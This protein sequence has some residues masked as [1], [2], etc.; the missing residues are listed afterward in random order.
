LSNS[1]SVVISAAKLLEHIVILNDFKARRT[2]TSRKFS[3][4]LRRSGP[5]QVARAR[6]AFNYMFQDWF[7]HY[8]TSEP[9]MVNALPPADSNA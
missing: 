3:P 5:P 7:A 9:A 1:I 8:E 2:I 4:A 6:P